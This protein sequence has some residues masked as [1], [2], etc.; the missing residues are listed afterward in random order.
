M[1]IF[2]AT[3]KSDFLTVFKFNTEKLTATDFFRRNLKQ[4]YKFVNEIQQIFLNLAQHF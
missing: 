1:N 2:W 4:F 3:I